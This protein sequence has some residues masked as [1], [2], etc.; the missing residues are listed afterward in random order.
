MTEVPLQPYALRCEF[1]TCPLGIDEL[2]PRLTWKL[3]SELRGQAQTGYRITVG[4]TPEDD[5][6]WDSGWLTGEDVAIE[7]GGAP[8]QSRTRYHWRVDVRDVDGTIAGSAS[9]WFETGVLHQDEWNAAWIERDHRSIPV[10]EPPQ[11]ND[12]SARTEHLTPPGQFRRSFELAN[13]T[14]ARVYVSAKGLYELRINGTRVGD[15]ELTPGWTDYRYRIQYQSYDVTEL[16][17]AGENVLA[18]TLADGWWSGFIGFDARHQ[19]QHYGKNPQLL[20]QLVIDHADGSCSTIATDS[21]WRESPGGLQFADPLMGEYRDA[22][23]ET[24]GWDTAGYD[25]SG[26][27]PVRVVSSDTSTLVAELDEPVRIVEELSAQRVVGEA[28]RQIVDLGQNMVGRVRLTVRGASP[29]QRITLR[30]AEVLNDEGELYTPNLRTAE[31]TDVYIAGE[32]NIEV[33]EPRFTFHGFRYVEVQGY[34]GDLRSSDVVGRVLCSGVEEV[35][36]FRCSDET[37]N[38]L[39]DNIRWGQRGNFVGVPTDC[40]QRDERLGWLAD[41]QVFLPTAC[42]NA[43]L[44]AFF[45]RWMRDVVDAQT[46]DG[47]FPDVAPQAVLDREGAPAWGDGGVIIP[48]HLYRVYGDRRVLRRSFHAMVAWVDH[49]HRHNPDLIWRHATG[50]NYGDWLQAGV[51]TPREVVATAYF[52]RSASIVALA[53]D[54]LGRTADAEHYEKLA[55]DIRAAFRDEFVDDR[56]QVSGHTQ[57]G[58]L[59]AIAG[60]LLTGET[61]SPAMRH[62]AA[63]ITARG[64]HLTTGFIGVPLLCPVLTEHGRS[65]LAYDLLHQ[66]GY[67]SWAYSIHRGATTIWERWDGWTEERGFQ[68]PAMNSFNHYSLG[69]IGE[70]LYRYVAGIDQDSESVG[71]R[72]LVLAPTPGGRLS[73]AQVHYESIRGL[74]ASAWRLR[75]TEI[76]V[77]VRIPPG[78]EA[79]V[80]IPCC[81]P[82]TAMENGFRLGD[83]PDV[84][85]IRTTGDEVVCRVRSGQYRFSASR[86]ANAS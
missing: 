26:W 70:W 78:A 6:L 74:I 31:A 77:D 49:I 22:R 67:P 41:A 52:A 34:P 75:D 68:S 27:S 33:F 71:Y 14:R 17:Q 64:S 16:L 63:D 12:R 7:Y 13:H 29:G 55:L 15:G 83:N 30:H 65:D 39:F 4:R 69:S 28:G 1:R 9:S 66:D 40:P 3:G 20:V 47:A 54:V 32:E 60:D 25:E 85:L 11:D 24:I 42:F 38:R 51:E 80:R 18:A 2:W 5:A 76:E 44:A 62:L 56:A 35:G 72:D 84:T 48:W 23:Q 46:A 58:Y 59:L 57:T 61:V 37:T 73:W 36:E 43:G 19:A 82:D 79:T 50:N 21:S 8:L 10:A 53:A 86:A 45:G 81:V